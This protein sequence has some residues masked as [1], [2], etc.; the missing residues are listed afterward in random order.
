MDT[1]QKSPKVSVVIPTYNRV[2]TVVR[3]IESVLTQT[4]QNLEIIVVDDGS[5]DNTREVIERLHD[6][7]VRYIRHGEN[8]GGSLARNTGIEAATGEYIAFLDSDDEWLPEK[9]ERQVQLFQRSEPCVG[10]VYCGFATV[11]EHGQITATRIP[12]HRGMILEELYTWNVI[13]ST[14]WVVMRR[15]CFLRVQPFDP[16]MPSCQDWDLWIRL[17]RYYEFDFIPEVLGR[18]HVDAPGR[19]TKNRRAVVEG[20]VRIAERYAKEAG[21]FSPWQRARHSFALGSRLLELGY[22]FKYPEPVRLGRQFL[23][24]AFL[25]HPLALR[26]LVHYGAS[27]NRLAYLILT[28]GGPRLRKLLTRRAA[29]LAG[30]EGVQLPQTQACDQFQQHSPMPEDASKTG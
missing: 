10:A 17:A 18:S 2:C 4:Y 21:S 8:R 14:S 1:A 5:T 27:S 28:R 22:D 16:A 9:L 3:A 13:P 25:A 30:S 24:A 20:H 19:I 29:A 26:H 6:P 12:E 23:L 7:R 11:G 15:E